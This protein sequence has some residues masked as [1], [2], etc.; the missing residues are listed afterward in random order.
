MS[1]HKIPGLV[2]RSSGIYYFRHGSPRQVW[3]SLKTRDLHT[4]LA[5]VQSIKL[6]GIQFMSNKPSVRDVLSSFNT[7][8]NSQFEID[9][10]NKRFSAQPG[11]DTKA[12]IDAVN[13]LAAAGVIG[14]KADATGSTPPAPQTSREKLIQKNRKAP[15]FKASPIDEAIEA[16]A[17]RIAQKNKSRTIY[18][19]LNHIKNFKAWGGKKLETVDDIDKPLLGVYQSELVKQNKEPKTI[20]NYFSSLSNFMRFCIN[21]GLTSHPTN[22]ASGMFILSKNERVDSSEPYKEYSTE[23]ITRIFKPETYLKAMNEPD[24]FWVPI[25]AY[26]TGMRASEIGCL[27]TDCFTF[28]PEGFSYINVKIT[29]TPNGRRLLPI[30][31][32]LMT[33]GLKTY[34]DECIK[35][36]RKSIFPFRITP[37]TW[38]G[39]RVQRKAQ[40]TYRDYLIDLGIKEKL[41]SLH[42]FRVFFITQIANMTDDNLALQRI[43]GHA[44]DNSEA[45]RQLGRY[46]RFLPKLNKIVQKF[47]P[48]GV[49]IDLEGLAYQAGRFSQFLAVKEPDDIEWPV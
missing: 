47:K 33:L 4:A 39:K 12:M 7:N 40:E 34:I 13:A 29:K 42:S 16:Y 48:E 26:Y 36:G 11:E 46:V 43:S 44:E 3:I 32:D 20:D 17:Q 27:T 14:T 9:L 35:A 30:H 22:P 6:S 37:A 21:Q 1:K 8:Q 45:M 2:Q 10:Q 49:Q 15:E 5:C 38:E 19:K 23:E 18:T 31:R 28:N 41:K 24:F 25:M